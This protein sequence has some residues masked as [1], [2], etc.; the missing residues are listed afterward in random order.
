MDFFMKAAMEHIGKDIDIQPE[1]LK[2]FHF[3]PWHPCRIKKGHHYMNTSSE[4]CPAVIMRF[5]KEKK[6]G[7]GGGHEWFKQENTSSEAI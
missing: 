7:C 5:E 3:P 1:Y 2:Q 4:S 6:K